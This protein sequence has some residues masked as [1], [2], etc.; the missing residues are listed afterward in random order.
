M[1]KNDSKKTRSTVVS[2]RLKPVEAERFWELE[3]AVAARHPYVDRADIVRELLGL[4]PCRAIT[5]AELNYF[6]TG[7]RVPKLTPTTLAIGTAK[8]AASARTNK[9]SKKLKN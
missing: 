8:P 4:V 7:E 1:S 3:D 9:G 5:V 6:R 2:I